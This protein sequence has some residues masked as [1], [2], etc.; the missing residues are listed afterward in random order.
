MS[1]HQARGTAAG[2]FYNP[3]RGDAVIDAGDSDRVIHEH[4][5]SEEE[6]TD[7]AIELLVGGGHLQALL[8]ELRPRIV[9]R[10]LAR[11]KERA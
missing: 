10:A 6:L 5:L 11:R 7:A 8:D 1:R 3:D 2:L 9:A 4:D